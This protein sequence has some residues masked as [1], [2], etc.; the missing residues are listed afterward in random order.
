MTTFAQLPTQARSVASCVTTDS[1]QHPFLD[2]PCDKSVLEDSKS[3][4]H[5]DVPTE[6]TEPDAG[7][8]QLSPPHRNVTRLIPRLGFPR[9]NHSLH[10]GKQHAS[11]THVS[12][13]LGSSK[14]L[15]TDILPLK[16]S[17][18]TPQLDD[19]RED[20]EDQLLLRN[21]GL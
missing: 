8:E 20:E 15:S 3:S 9:G 21:M 17:F 5:I 7:S 14:G 11:G 12:L 2:R 1:L 4:K 19:Q 10:V 13:V 16:L 18:S 6:D